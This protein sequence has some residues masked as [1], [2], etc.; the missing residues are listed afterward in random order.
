MALKLAESANVSKKMFYTK[1]D[2]GKNAKFNSDFES[3][4]QKVHPKN[5]NPK[6]FA[7]SKKIKKTPFSVTF[8]LITFLACV[9]ASY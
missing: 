2:M 4:V 5:Y 1:F 7:L 8:S 6:T 9:F 3:V